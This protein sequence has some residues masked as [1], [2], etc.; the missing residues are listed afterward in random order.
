MYDLVDILV[1]L[2]QRNLEIIQPGLS[3][4][5]KMRLFV[6]RRRIKHVSNSIDVNKDTSS[7]LLREI[8]RLPFGEDQKECTISLIFY[9][10]CI[11]EILKSYTCVT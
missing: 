6:M 8:V 7:Y 3:V 5:I 10:S 11:S 2:H 9:S 4:L 1:K